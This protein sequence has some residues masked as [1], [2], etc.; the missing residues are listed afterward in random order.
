MIHF[1][2]KIGSVAEEILCVKITAHQWFSTAL[3]LLKLVKIYNFYPPFGLADFRNFV[4]SKLIYSDCLI[5][6]CIISLLS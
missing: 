5:E 6:Y 1:F 2:R 4:K 3:N